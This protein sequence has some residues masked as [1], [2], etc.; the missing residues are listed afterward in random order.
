L[1]PD[2]LIP[3]SSNPQSLNRYSYTQNNPINS[4]DPSGHITCVDQSEKF[5]GTEEECKEIISTWLEVLGSKGG[6]EGA[7]VA[8]YFKAADEFTSYS[9]AGRKTDKNLLTVTVV[10]QISGGA[11]AQYGPNNVSNTFLVTADMMD[12]PNAEDVGSLANAGAFGHEINHLQHDPYRSLNPLD[13]CASG[14]KRGEVCAYVVQNKIYKNMGLNAEND[15]T[16]LVSQAEDM[17]ALDGQ[18]GE[19]ILANETMKN[20]ER[21]YGNIPLDPFEKLR[22]NTKPIVDFFKSLRNRFR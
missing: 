9:R 15:P 20:K 11:T 1:Q 12:I 21:G 13:F 18:P 14:T 19:K 4:I 3:D 5:T 8:A 7:K 17:A 2:S 10:D 22:N 16:G 6:E